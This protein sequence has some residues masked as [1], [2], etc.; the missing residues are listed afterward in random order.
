MRKS[1]DITGESKTLITIVYKQRRNH[2]KYYIK[3]LNVIF[4]NI[5]NILISLP[6]LV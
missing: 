4:F 6:H 1:R 5:I 3:Y 2:Y